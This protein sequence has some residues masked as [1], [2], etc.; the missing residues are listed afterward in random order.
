MAL[1]YYH[2]G[3]KFRPEL[4]EFRL[5]IQKA[6][7]AIDNS[8]G[9]PKDYKFQPPSSVR[10]MTAGAVP[11]ST[12]SGGANIPNARATI[13]A[14]GSA[15]ESYG[16]LLGEL[17][18]D[19]IYLESLLND[20]DFV[21]NPNDEICSL[22]S[23]ALNYLET[24][25]EFWRQQKPIYARR[26]EYSKV[27]A[28]AISDRNRD[29]IH[30]KANQFL[31]R[32]PDQRRG[33]SDVEDEEPKKERPSSSK[34]ESLKAINASMNVING[35]IERG[36]LQDALKS[37]KSL[38]TRLNN[39][40]GLD[41]RERA[42]SDVLSTIGNIYLEMDNLPQAMQHHRKDLSLSRSH[43]M[44]DCISRAL[45]NIGRTCVR[46]KRFEEAITSF[47]KK[48]VLTPAG[49][50]ERAW[51]LHDIGRCNLELGSDD[52]AILKA[53]ECLAIAE[54]LKDKRWALNAHVLAAQAEGRSGRISQSISEYTS[55]LLLANDL[56]DARATEAI[57]QAMELTK[58]GPQKTGA[59][60]AKEPKKTVMKTRSVS[61]GSGVRAGPSTSRFSRP[62]VTATSSTK[63][64]AV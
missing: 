38:L 63:P 12:T 42:I 29:L 43:G 55:A 14:P 5:G 58:A 50:L 47:E 6:R 60:K 4:D 64:I 46:L 17:Y 19:K 56:H 62:T 26:K 41:N 20:K 31:E 11:T 10:P 27:Q 36:D 34:P 9:N 33:K 8:I 32:H 39:M 23:E 61:A 3:N 54:A 15:K 48:L 49:T 45:G 2:R 52:T 16:V 22:V 30:S 25:T 7:E 59:M 37:A 57:T 21:H 35:A 13:M 18:S 28:K 44:A 40:A 51:L 1:V 24:R 53:N